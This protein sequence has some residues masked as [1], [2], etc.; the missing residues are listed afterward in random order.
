MES[1]GS[2]RVH[3]DMVLVNIL[4][5]SVFF[6]FLLFVLLVCLFV[7]LFVCFFVCLLPLSLLL[8]TPFKMLWLQSF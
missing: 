1:V 8:L 2:K 7:C 4:L 6:V 3:G 5:F